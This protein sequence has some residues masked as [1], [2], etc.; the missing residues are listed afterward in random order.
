MYHT[1]GKLYQNVYLV[2]GIRD[3]DLHMSIISRPYDVTTTTH[4][5]DNTPTG[6]EFPSRFCPPKQSKTRGGGTHRTQKQKNG[7]FGMISPRSLHTH[8]CLAR[9]LHLSPLP[10][11]SAWKLARG[12]CAT[13]RAWQSHSYSYDM[14]VPHTCREISY[15]QQKL[16]NATLRSVRITVRT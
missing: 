12:G 11:S 14:Y 9:Y 1:Y 16:C 15:V 10:R 7:G 5:Q 8:R 6:N 2:P 3:S 4:G 13:Y